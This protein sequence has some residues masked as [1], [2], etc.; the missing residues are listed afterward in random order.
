V[1]IGPDSIQIV[2]QGLEAFSSGEIERIVEM[3]HADFEGS[4]PPELSTE[5]DTYRGHEGIRRYFETFAEA[6]DH[7]RFEPERFWKAGPDVVVASVRMTGRG[8]QTS[9]PIE[10]RNAQVWTLR[11]GKLWRGVTYASLSAA[12]AAAGLSATSPPA[13]Q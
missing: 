7:I 13:A 11:E 4:V 5:P 8:R 2:R 12:L 6:V 3:T 10:Q 9:I 1:L